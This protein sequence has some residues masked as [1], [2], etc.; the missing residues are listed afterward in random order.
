MPHT[1]SRGSHA[2]ILKYMDRES[3][4]KILL[5]KLPQ[6]LY[7]DPMCDFNNEVF[8]TLEN[9]KISEIFY[10]FFLVLQFISILI[11]NSMIT[12]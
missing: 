9:I 11:I 10:F 1:F 12:F 6:I 4:K 7:S 2:Y 8:F 3:V 5:T